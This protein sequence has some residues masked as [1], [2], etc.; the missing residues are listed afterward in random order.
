V[1]GGSEAAGAFDKYSDIDL[2]AFCS[3][4]PDQEA[5]REAPAKAGGRDSRISVEAEGRITNLDEE[6]AMLRE[7]KLN[8]A[9]KALENQDRE[10][11]GEVSILVEI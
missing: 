4:L 7:E 2:V 10:F 5:V 8:Q 11:F 9:A 1:L 6:E 3:S